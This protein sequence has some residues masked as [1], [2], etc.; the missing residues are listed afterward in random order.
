[1]CEVQC[2]TAHS[3]SGHGAEYY[4]LHDDTRLFDLAAIRRV[5]DHLPFERRDVRL[6]RSGVVVTII[7]EVSY[8]WPISCY[9][10]SHVFKGVE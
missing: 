10:I 6:L 1:M 2:I 3:S 5:H 9:S 4:C 8:L 7:D